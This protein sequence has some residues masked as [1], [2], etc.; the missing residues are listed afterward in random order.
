MKL[1]F[2]DPSKKLERVNSLSSSASTQA[3]EDYELASY[4]YTSPDSDVEKSAGIS[5]VLS[6]SDAAT[7]YNQPPVYHIRPHP[8]YVPQ[9]INLSGDEFVYVPTPAS[10]VL[11]HFAVQQQDLPVS[12]TYSQIDSPTSET[13]SSTSVVHQP[14]TKTSNSSMPTVHSPNSDLFYTLPASSAHDLRAEQV[15]SV[16]S[17]SPFVDPPPTSAPISQPDT[18][19]GPIIQVMVHKTETVVS[20]LS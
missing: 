6:D 17:P 2:P 8:E 10:L 14:K 9:D 18:E 20:E 3:G 4:K 7:L 15:T 13:S 16:T 1:S 5:P 19:E 12:P 11:R